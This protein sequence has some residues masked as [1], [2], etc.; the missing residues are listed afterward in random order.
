MSHQ[1]NQQMKMN[2]AATRED[3]E[4]M[5]KITK[6]AAHIYEMNMEPGY[7]GLMDISACHSNG[8]PLQL[9]ELLDARDSDFNHDVAGI[10]RHI[11]RETGKLDGQFWPRYAVKQ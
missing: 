2:F 3:Y 4:I 6:R 8:C 11:D 10:R 1:P 7:Y 5:F 9:Q